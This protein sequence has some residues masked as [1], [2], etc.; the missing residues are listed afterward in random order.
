MFICKDI[1]INDLFINEKPLLNSTGFFGRYKND[2]Q[3]HIPLFWKTSDYNIAIDNIDKNYYLT[4]NKDRVNPFIEIKDFLIKNKLAYLGNIKKP[5]LWFNNTS[6][7][8]LCLKN[9]QLSKNLTFCCFND[10]YSINQ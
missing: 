6:N 4:L 1:D 7:L 3:G 8:D 10:N 5:D 2:D 9:L